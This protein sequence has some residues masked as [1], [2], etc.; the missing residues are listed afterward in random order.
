LAVYELNI[1]SSIQLILLNP[2]ILAIL[3]GLESSNTLI[4][5]QIAAEIDI[6]R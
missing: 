2:I 6:V 1:F 4:R 3:K 5:Q